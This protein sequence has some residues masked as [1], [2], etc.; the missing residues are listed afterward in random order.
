MVVTTCARL[1]AAE[2]AAGG[3]QRNK[4]FKYVDEELDQDFEVP[5]EDVISAYKVGA[6]ADSLLL[7]CCWR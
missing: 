4:V 5:E 3:V 7:C 6:C 1:P 2:G